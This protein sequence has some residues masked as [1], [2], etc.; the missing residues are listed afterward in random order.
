M[1]AGE[2]LEHYAMPARKQADKLVRVEALAHFSWE[3]A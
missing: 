2:R 1:Q 3:R